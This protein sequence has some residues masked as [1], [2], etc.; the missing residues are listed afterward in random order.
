MSATATSN[1]KSKRPPV[2]TIKLTGAQLKNFKK[3]NLTEE[4]SGLATELRTKIKV[5]KLD[6]LSLDEDNDKFILTIKTSD[7]T[8]RDE[9]I[10][11][12]KI[13]FG[14][15]TVIS[16][17]TQESNNS[18]FLII[19]N[20]P[21]DFKENDETTKNTMKINHGII[22]MKRFTL[23]NGSLSSTMTAQT[24][25]QAS[26]FKLI[27]EGFYFETRT[28]ANCSPFYKKVKFCSNCVSYGHYS[29]YC[30]QISS[31]CFICG[32]SHHYS[33]CNASPKCP[34]C[35]L[36]NEKRNTTYSLDH[37]SSTAACPIYANEFKKLNEI[38]YSTIDNLNNN[39]EFKYNII[40][41]IDSNILNNKTKMKPSS[42]T[43]N[44]TKNETE[45]MYN[46]LEKKFEAFQEKYDTF[47]ETYAK[48]QKEITTTISLMK[49]SYETL[50]K[51]MTSITKTTQSTDQLLRGFINEYRTNSNSRPQHSYQ[52][53]NYYNHD[54]DY[55]HYHR[56]Q[57]N[58]RSRAG[59]NS[60]DS[61]INEDEMNEQ[62]M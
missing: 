28:R 14:G 49:S 38:Y 12:N 33:I 62:T 48:D 27:N 30:D 40:I 58:K 56:N 24:I 50:N 59:P 41:P 23:P 17:T 20:I 18:L 22:N 8:S 57:A 3:S 61:L 21:A 16:N 52:D 10:S 60:S 35:N 47:Q 34:H 36:S 37:L 46:S 43:N 54:H 44:E 9:I 11:K 32:E 42:S 15:V 26:F 53:Y 55:N 7:N 45:K 1:M 31:T 2:H 5:Y 4:T 13:I 29:S 39:N 6:F 19:Q 25:D 51:K